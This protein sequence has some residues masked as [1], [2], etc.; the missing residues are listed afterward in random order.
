M[1]L[2]EID[3]ENE[4]EVNP[5][6]EI[7]IYSET[8]SSLSFQTRPWQCHIICRL[9]VEIVQ[10]HKYE[11]ENSNAES[12]HVL[13]PQVTQQKR[14]RKLCK[15]FEKFYT[16]RSTSSQPAGRGHGL[17]HREGEARGEER[18]HQD[19]L[20]HQEVHRDPVPHRGT[21]VDH[22]IDIITLVLCIY[23]CFSFPCKV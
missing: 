11:A 23:I 3:E 21:E 15:L 4:S 19:P 5:N 7:Q 1:S 13:L 18:G 6:E 10:R 16:F 14:T 20:P 17:L 8:F 12:S 2:R 9:Q 22:Y